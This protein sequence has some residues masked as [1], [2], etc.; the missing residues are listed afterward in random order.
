MTQGEIAKLRDEK[1]ALQGQLSQI[2]QT[3][4]II[5]ALKPKAPVPAYLVPNTCCAGY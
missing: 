5:D 1:L 4:T 2:S 3:S